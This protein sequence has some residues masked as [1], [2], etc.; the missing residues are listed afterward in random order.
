VLLAAGAYTPSRTK[1]SGRRR[2]ASS[3][4]SCPDPRSAGAHDLPRQQC[5]GFSFTAGGAGSPAR[6][7]F[8]FGLRAAGRSLLHPELVHRPKSVRTFLLEP[9]PT[10][11]IGHRRSVGKRLAYSACTGLSKLM[12]ANAGSVVRLKSVGLSGEE[13]VSAQSASRARRCSARGDRMRRCQHCSGEGNN[14]SDLE[15][16]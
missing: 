2:S 14:S 6:R 16:M 3:V 4:T 13:R 11:E 12:K 10:I 7:R 15:P 9:V 5:R 1:V 8:G